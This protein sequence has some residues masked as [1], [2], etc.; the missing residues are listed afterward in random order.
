[1]VEEIIEIDDDYNLDAFILTANELVTEMCTGTKGPQAPNEY[2]DA[3]LELIERWLTAHFYHILDQ[4]IK[5]EAAGS[6]RGEY[7]HKVDLNLAVTTYGQQAMMLDTNGALFDLSNRPK[8]TTADLAAADK[9]I[10]VVFISGIT[11]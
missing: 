2:S 10:D 6:V 3:R 9:P 4:R 7:Q 1:M 11:K 5:T 8:P